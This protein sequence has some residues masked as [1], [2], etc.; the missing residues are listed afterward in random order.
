[1]ANVGESSNGYIAKVEGTSF[2]ECVDNAQK[3]LACMDGQDEVFAL[4][5]YQKNRVI[6]R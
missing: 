1:M 6:M 3:K 2:Y 4:D 5:L